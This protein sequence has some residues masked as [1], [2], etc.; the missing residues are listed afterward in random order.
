MMTTT[1]M[2]EYDLYE[3]A[4]TPDSNI[5]SWLK[6]FPSARAETGG[7]RLAKHWPPIFVEF[8]PGADSARIRQY[9][10]SLEARSAITPHI[11][12]LSDSGV[13]RPCQSAWNAPLLPVKKPHSKAYRP[14]QDLWEVSKRVMDIQPNSAQS[15]YLTKCA[16]PGISTVHSPG[17]ERYFFQP[18]P[19]P[20]KPGLFC[21]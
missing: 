6:K 8:K 11:R 4:L 19:S 21:L 18:S 12:R 1:L 20:Q 10:M 5:K 17:F 3:P 16:P 15:L 13:L 9:P 7:L 14:V 2:D